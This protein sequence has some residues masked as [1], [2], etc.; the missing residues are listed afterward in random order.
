MSL[1]WNME[2]DM[3]F[4]LFIHQDSSVKGEVF[5]NIMEQNFME[6]RIQTLKTFNM[7]KSELKQVSNDDKYIFIL[8]TDSIKRL[9]K[10]TSLIDLMEG[11]RIILILPD[12]TKS[13]ISSAHK[14][15]PRYFTYINDTYDDLCDVLNKITHK[16]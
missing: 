1:I 9:I 10:L 16:V 11:K 4:I 7:L 3:H 14:F 6:T 8:F 13:A 15:F 12:D 2:L 5:K